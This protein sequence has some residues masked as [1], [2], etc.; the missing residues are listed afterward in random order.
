[1]LTM[2]E[3]EPSRRHDI[4]AIHVSGGSY[5]VIDRY[6]DAVYRAAL[7]V[8]GCR[9][10]AED[11]TQ[12]VFLKY[13]QTR[14]SFRS[15]AHEKAWFLRVAVNM[16]KNLVRSPWHRRRTDADLTVIPDPGSGETS[17]SGVLAAVLSLPEKYR[18]AIYLYCYEG[19]TAR[20]IAEITGRSEAA[21]A[22]HLSRGRAKLR[23]LLGGDAS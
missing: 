12:E 22:Q 11:I 9:A 1:M 8:T 2:N 21:V 16:G 3:S 23:K 4:G 19:Y 18:V 5:A 20:E 17:S 6:K 10:D 14:P 7:T 13:F 15:E